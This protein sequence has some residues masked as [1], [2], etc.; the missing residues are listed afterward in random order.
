MSSAVHDRRPF[1]VLLRNLSPRSAILR[2][3]AGTF[4]SAGSLKKS[5]YSFGIFRE[6]VVMKKAVAAWEGIRSH[7]L[8]HALGRAGS[9]MLLAVPLSGCAGGI[10]QPRGETGA[11]SSKILLDAVGIMSVIVV[12]TIV[13]LM[14]IGFWFR[15]SNTRARYQPS[16]VYSGRL[17]IIVWSIP[18][19]VIM[20]L[21][22][23][24]WI[25]SH[26]LDPFVPIASDAKDPPLEVQV[27]SLDWKWLFIYPQQRIASVNELVVPVGTPVHFFLTSATVMN[28]FFVPQL[29]SMIATMNGMQTQLNLRADHLGNYSGFSAQYSG[30][31]FS[32]MHFTV[33]AVT[34]DDFQHWAAATQ[35]QRGPA[36]DRNGYFDLLRESCD[37]EPFTYSSADPTLFSAVVKR[38][39][40]PGPGPYAGRAGEGVRSV[41]CG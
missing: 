26:E 4:R 21:G 3:D 30:D 8:P 12:P 28:Q 36:L 37:V 24:T 17:E 41:G 15:A 16:F 18:I 13:A 33:R 29:G 1:Q 7:A 22:G 32:G 9:V 25:G 2:P 34:Q 38:D 6:G 5:E 27:I 20:F 11:A 10:L 14:V 23:L 39:L 19:L 40:P 35:Q 31:G